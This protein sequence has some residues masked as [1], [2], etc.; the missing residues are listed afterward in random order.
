MISLCSGWEFTPRWTDDFPLGAGEYETV[1]LPH[2][3]REVPLHYALPEH[4]ETVCG[5][6][7]ALDIP[8]SY[9]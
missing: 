1:R 5:Y 3:V 7:R 9:A 4:Y 2:T 8:A 6:R